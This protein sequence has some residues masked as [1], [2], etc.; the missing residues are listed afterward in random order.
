MIT[1][2]P[3][4]E[5][6][7]P[8]SS[9]KLTCNANGNPVP[10]YRWY[11]DCDMN[12]TIANEKIHLIFDLNV[13]KTGTYVCFAYNRLNGS[14]YKKSENIVIAI[15]KLKLNQVCENY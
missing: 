15:G 3:F 9:V 13:N 2:E 10:Y 11:K 7:T 14:T 12:S 1:K 5:T 8:G 4:M 6:Y